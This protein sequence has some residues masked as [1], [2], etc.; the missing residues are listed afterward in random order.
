[1]EIKP[2]TQEFKNPLRKELSDYLQTDPTIEERK[3]RRGANRKI[4]NRDIVEGIFYHKLQPQKSGT[5]SEHIGELTGIEVSDS[6]ISQRRMNMDNSVFDKI[7]SQTLKPIANETEHSDCFYNGLRLLAIDGT[8]S[9]V[10]NSFQNQEELS[11][12]KGGAKNGKLHSASFASLQWCTLVEV[13]CHNPIAV[14]ISDES[15]E[16]ERNLSKKLFKQI[17]ERSLVLL[18]A[19]YGQAKTCN[20][21]LHSLRP[22][23][24]HFLL[25]LNPVQGF[26]V[27]EKLS[28]GSQLVELNIRKGSKPN[29]KKVIGKI[30]LRKLSIEITQPDGKVKMI[31]LLTDLLDEKTYPA[32]E[33]MHIYKK[34]WE[35]EIF[36]CELKVVLNHNDLLQ[37][38]TPQTAYQE[39]LALVLVCGFM[40]LQKLNINKGTSP[41][42]LSYRKSLNLI[43]S[44]WTVLSLSTN[45]LSNEQMEAMISNMHER[46]KALANKPRRKRSCPRVRHTSRSERWPRNRG[47]VAVNQQATM[48]LIS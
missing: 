1:M 45:I 28:D 43:T 19:L 8:C 24:S 42:T 6:C 13:G 39:I 32:D 7:A 15:Q 11:K 3:E 44:F 12:H 16:I 10:R 4:S 37:S 38:N 22:K 47:Q 36:Y 48:K 2:T 31:H 41:L 20:E 27:K 40:A 5:L 23:D 30:T 26:N 46:I 17:P 18:D 14:A 21:L 25:G 34:R 33:L 9:Q 35:Q 29:A